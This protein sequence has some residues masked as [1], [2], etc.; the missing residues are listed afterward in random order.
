MS[1]IVN[2]STKNLDFDDIADSLRNFMRYQEEF[3]D[4]DFKGSALNSLINVLA[5]NTHYNGVYDNFVIN[6]SFLDSSVKRSSVISHANLV[7]YTPRS[8]KCATAKVSIIVQDDTIYD[9]DKVFQMSADSVFNTTI[10]GETYSF[11]A[12]ETMQFA[13]SQSGYILHGVI[14]E[15]GNRIT[16]TQRYNGTNGQKFVLANDGIDIDTLSV[17]VNHEGDEYTFVRAT[18]LLDIDNNSKVYFLTMNGNG[19]YQIQFGSG[20]MGFSLSANDAVTIS[21][22][23]C[24]GV[25]AN[26]AR[27]FDYVGTPADFGF[28]KD[29]TMTVVCTQKSAGGGQPEDT[30]SI[31]V[32]APKMYTTQNRCVT[33]SDYQN[34]IKSMYGNVKS[35]KVWGGDKMDP[36]QYGKVFISIIP[37]EGLTL[38][39]AEKNIVLDIVEKRRVIGFGDVQV[40]DP[41]IINIHVD[42]TVYYDPNKS[43]NSQHDIETLVKNAILKYNDTYL[44]SFESVL[45][46]SKL[47]SMID[48]CDG[49]VAVQNNN[50]KIQ[51]SGTITPVFGTAIGYTL[52]M[53][54]AIYKPKI[55]SESVISTGFF[56]EEGKNNICFID[57][58]PVT[59]KLR[60]FYI[61]DNSEKTVIQSVGTV[62]Y[63][64]GV[65]TIDKLTMTSLVGQ[66]WS[67]M[68]N[69]SS[70]DVMTKRNQFA[71]ID[72]H[73]INVQ[74]LGIASDGSY[75]QFSSK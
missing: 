73:N 20:M 30:E 43:I 1:N 45:R 42:S 38:S 69:P 18:E 67:F 35:I 51:I 12:K 16:T 39:N 14:L 48:R 68:I 24:D 6:E 17:K 52:D 74:C 46:F 64:T 34:V 71:V 5:Y 3:T 59:R 62:D 33:E 27:S 13:Q 56:C 54:N 40:V 15:Q 44:G 29:A 7:N 26:N 23:T 50:T 57:D 58:D 4:Y 55:A 70:N 37:K 66:T 10:E 63:E 8:A 32:M 47:S 60:L 21:Y 2:Y 36:P 31:R 72:S 41:S 53:S 11:I 49:E 28:S 25:K 61:N 75:V 19:Q 9:V 22:I 65:L